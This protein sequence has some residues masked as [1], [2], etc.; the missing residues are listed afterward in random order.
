MT[1]TPP[2]GPGSLRNKNQRHICTESSKLVCQGPESNQ[3]DRSQFWVSYCHPHSKNLPRAN[4][5][6]GTKPGAMVLAFWS[7]PHTLNSMHNKN[8]QQSNVGFDC[9]RGYARLSECVGRHII[10]LVIQIQ[11][12]QMK[13]LITINLL[14]CQWKIP[15][16]FLNDPNKI[17]L[18]LT[19][20]NK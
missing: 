20:K 6:P 11:Y 15:G 3:A 16:G 5:D 4:Y 12:V 10:F 19:Q 18:E 9:I 1:K 7:I 13:M 8:I 2:N 14:K 17:I